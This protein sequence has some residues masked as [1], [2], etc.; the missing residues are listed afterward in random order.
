MA[1]IPFTSY[2]FPTTDAGTAT[3]PRSM[4]VRLA[5]VKNVI[6]FGADPTGNAG[7][8]TATRT[9]IQNAIDATS[10]PNRGTIYFP[11]GV[12]KVDAP[13]T[14]NYNGNLSICFRGE[15][16]ASVEG[17]FADYVFKRALGTPNN[18]PGGRVFEGLGITNSHPSGG[19]LQLGST[20]GG[21]IRDCGFSGFIGIT[22][23]DAPGVSSKNISIIDCQFGM[24]AGTETGAHY[25]IIGGGGSIQ[26][27]ALVG[28]DTAVRAYGSGLHCSG[29]RQE[30]NNTVWLLGKDS[31]NNPVG[32]SGFSIVGSTFEGNWIGFDLAGPCNGF[33]IGSHHMMGHDFSNAGFKR[34]ALTARNTLFASRQ[35]AQEWR[36]LRQR[37]RQLDGN[38]RHFHRQRH[39]AR[40]CCF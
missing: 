7:T 37:C 17:G 20:I 14:F 28:T 25:I 27:C 5:E 39:D 36:L 19:C 16:G 2:Q 6:D 23:E 8:A 9:A 1:D 10:G 34:L 13:I 38:R 32:L 24:G 30:R 31:A 35:T 12:Y 11:M 15:L 40:Q 26:N 22:T 29:N 18:T 21:V 33:Y 3:H 4:P